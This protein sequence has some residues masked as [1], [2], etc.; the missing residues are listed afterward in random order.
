MMAQAVEAPSLSRNQVEWLRPELHKLPNNPYAHTDFTAYTL[1]WGEV[2]LGIS[3]V[4]VGIF[5]RTQLGTSVPLDVLGFHNVGAKVNLLRLGPWDVGLSGSWTG[6][7]Q[8]DFALTYTSGGLINS[9]Q[10]TR[11]WSFHVGATYAA[12]GLDGLPD[13]SAI[14]PILK[15]DDAHLSL[16][17]DPVHYVG[18]TLTVQVASDLRLN[19]RDS[20]ILQGK[21]LVWNDTDGDAV[22]LVM[23]IQAVHQVVSSQGWRTPDEVYSVSLAYQADLKRMSMRVGVGYSTLPMAW[24]LQCFELSYRFGGQYKRTERLQRRTWRQ[25][26][27]DVES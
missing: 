17:M 8:P 4:Q 21:A 19:R 13:P 12:L 6:F 18:E 20:L 7:Q 15:I 22:D 11:K 10:I 9:L 1:Q 25:N 14:H 2:K 16:M 27:K 3:N 26:R 5:P 24:T 23:P